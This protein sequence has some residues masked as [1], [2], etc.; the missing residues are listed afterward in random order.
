M[1]SVFI[2]ILVVAPLVFFIIK[3]KKGLDNWNDMFERNTISTSMNMTMANR[4]TE[5]ALKA[6]AY[7]VEE[8]GE[9]LQ[10]YIDSKKSNLSEFLN[11]GME[12]NLKFD[13]LVDANQVLNEGSV[14]C[15]NLRKIEKVP[16]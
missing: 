1:L 16:L 8:I 4:S 3:S 10:A 15:N 2:L 6:L 9:P 7:S 14:V 13:V 12:T 5:E 11:T